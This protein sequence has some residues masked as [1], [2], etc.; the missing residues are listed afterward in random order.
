MKRLLAGL[1]IL[2][3]LPSAGPAQEGAVTLRWKWE[4]GRE[5][6]Y[7]A[8]RRSVAE[9]SGPPMT[10]DEGNT[11]AMTVTEVADSGEA[12][13]TMKYLAVSSRGSSPLGEYDYDSEKDK[14]APKEGPGVLYSRLVGQSFTI[15][16]TAA[17]RVMDVQGFEKVLDSLLQGAGDDA[18][19]ARQQLKPAFSNDAFKATMQQMAPSL[20]DGPVKVGDTWTNSFVVKMPM[21]GSVTYTVTSKLTEIRDQKAFLSQQIKMDLKSADA[22]N[23]TGIPT[24]VKDTRASSEAVFSI[25]KGCFLS[26]KAA[27]EMTMSIGGHA[28]TMK[29]VADLNLVEKK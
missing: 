24:E 11:Y 22:N 5:L 15:K 8:M 10:Q 16:M 3:V 7:K 6:V 18:P 19:R 29:T 2:L 9:S 17:G 26:Q 12:T 28:V 27:T 14:V 20:P 23:P 13:I 4:K 25:E 1:A 21:V